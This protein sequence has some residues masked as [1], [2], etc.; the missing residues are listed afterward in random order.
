[1][2]DFSP[3]IVADLVA[4][5]TEGLSETAE[6]LSRALDSSITVEVGEAATLDRD[7]LPEQC[8]GPGLAFV[9]VIGEVAAVVTIPESSGMLPDWYA[10][11]VP[12][13][14]S[15]LATLAQ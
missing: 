11:P 8:A 4:A 12:T 7:N 5:C 9:L 15:K 10:D 1:M 13:G 6:A 3:E 2:A 14:E